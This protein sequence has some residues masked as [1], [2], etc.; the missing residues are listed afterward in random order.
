MFEGTSNDTERNLRRWLQP[1]PANSYDSWIKVGAWIKSVV[2]SGEID[3]AQGEAIFTDW[4]IA[5][6]EGVKERRN[7][8]AVIERTWESL[9]GGRNGADG[10]VRAN[11]LLNIRRLYHESILEQLTADNY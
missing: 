6:Y 1:I 10:F 7:D 11:G 9:T 2:Y 5:N 3:E 4:S 8:P